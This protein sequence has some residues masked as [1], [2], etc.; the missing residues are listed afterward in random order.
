MECPSKNV[1]P[2]SHN[3]GLRRD[4]TRKCPSWPRLLSAL[5]DCPVLLADWRTGKVASVLWRTGGL[6]DWRTGGLADCGPHWRTGDLGFFPLCFLC[7]GG[8][9][10]GLADWRTGGLADWQQH[11]TWQPLAQQQDCASAAVFCMG[12]QEMQQSICL[13]V[14]SVSHCHCDVFA[15]PLWRQSVQFM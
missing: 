13:L 15:R 12:K 8:L 4:R 1:M 11:R 6:R 9:A 14:R 10:G 7:T 2:F 5:A 3:Q